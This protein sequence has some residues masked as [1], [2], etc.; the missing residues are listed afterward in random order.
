MSGEIFLKGLC[1]IKILHLVLTL[2]TVLEGK[3]K[4]VLVVN[5]KTTLIKLKQEVIF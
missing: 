2:N 1:E 5:T 4:V 3:K